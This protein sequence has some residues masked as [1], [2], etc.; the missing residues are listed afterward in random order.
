MRDQGKLNCRCLFRF[1]EGDMKAF[2]GSQVK[3]SRLTN[4]VRNVVVRGFKD[5]RW[6]SKKTTLMTSFNADS[7]REKCFSM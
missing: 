6:K 3:L 5:L 4:C 1:I 2:S 7:F